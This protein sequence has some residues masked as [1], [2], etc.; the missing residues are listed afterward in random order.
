MGTIANLLGFGQTN[1]PHYQL[2]YSTATGAGITTMSQATLASTNG[3]ANIIN[4]SADGYSVVLRS[5]VDV[6]P[7]AGNGYPRSEWRELQTNGTSLRAFNGTTGEHKC[8]VLLYP[9]HLPPIK[10]SFVMVQV[11]DADQDVLEVAMQ[12]NSSTGVLDV[13]GRVA[14]D[15]QSGSSSG[16]PKLISDFQWGNWIHAWIRVGAI[17]PG[18]VAGWEFY[19]NGL[20]VR[21]WDTD[22]PEADFINGSNA[23][24]KSGM[25][26][27][28]KWTGSGTGGLETDRN[29]YGE[30]AW[31]TFRTYHNGE[32]SPWLAAV[33]T[34]TYDA[35][36]N[37]RAGAKTSGRQATVQTGISLTPALPASPTNKTM[38]LCIVRTSRGITSTSA[39]AAT[40]AAPSPNSAPSTPSMPSDWIPL[41][42]TRMPVSS[43]APLVGAYPTGPNLQTHTVRWSLFAKP[44]VSGDAAPTVS[45]GLGNTTTDTMSAVII[46]VD[47]AR[48]ATT[49]ADLIDKAPAG[50]D[51]A[52]PNDPTTIGGTES[53]IT[54]AA[55]T[56]TTLLGPTGAITGAAPGSL[57]IACVYHETNASSGSVAAVTGTDSPALTWAELC[58]GVT[59]T[60]SPAA[61]TASSAENEPAWAVDYAI[62][63]GSAG[64]NIV[65]KTAA[66]TIA[67]DA[68]KPSGTL[69]SAGKGWGVLFTIQ[70]AQQ[71]RRGHRAA[72]TVG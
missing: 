10:P 17:A 5:D 20:F 11:H 51:L 68:N 61:G 29:E 24:F 62:I 48:I 4:P 33:G 37:V 19:C 1:G 58:E 34:P 3:V 45:Y 66:A 49:I 40:S 25:Y 46:G 27:Q 63:P 72:C 69:T 2:D 55:A 16:I 53:G 47:D 60:I 23:Y 22:M 36:T 12:K 57:A 31:R 39:T 30:A 28:T 32:A 56:S 35:V 8:E 42:R 71:R 13:V 65:A 38:M 43:T 50:L 41:I 7:I 67:A 44:W 21:S 52:N 18:S 54:F 70:P 64:Q 26:L 14:H 15:G 6:D 59:T 9:M